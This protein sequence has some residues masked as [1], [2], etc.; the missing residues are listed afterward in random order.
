M[1]RFWPIR[2]IHES[3]S[4]LPMA[5]HLSFFKLKLQAPLGPPSRVC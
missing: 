5:N 4:L 2:E 1:N 3:G